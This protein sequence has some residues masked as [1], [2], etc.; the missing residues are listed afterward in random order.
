MPIDPAR[1]A[2]TLS[3]IVTNLPFI[4][5]ATQI[6]VYIFLIL[7]LG[8]IAIVGYRGFL[9]FWKRL[10][11]RIIFGFLCLISAVSLAD[12]IPF[13]NQGI[14]Q[15]FHISMLVAG[16]LSSIVFAFSLYIISM[17]IPR[18]EAIKAR[19]REL[20]EKL[21][22]IKDKKPPEHRFFN[23]FAIVGTLII[24]VFLLFVL[25]NFHGFPSFSQDIYSFFGFSQEDMENIGSMLGDIEGFQDIEGCNEIMNVLSQNADLLTDPNVWETY[26]NYDL[27]AK[28]KSETGADIAGLQKAEQ[29]GTAIILGIVNATSYCIATENDIC[30]C[31]K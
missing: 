7:F 19:I 10:L 15:L 27:Q 3:E 25:I 17:R 30:Y 21:D 1:L 29:N 26:I 11:L 16:I 8:S 24:V 23:P 20:E 14:Y 12:F 13:F 6:I 28:M 5:Q 31:K 18:S 9:S 2:G 4:L 22:K